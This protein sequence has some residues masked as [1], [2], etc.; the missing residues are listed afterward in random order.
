MDTLDEKERYTHLKEL[1]DWA[2]EKLHNIGFNI[3]SNRDN[4]SPGLITISL[5]N[6]LSSSDLGSKLQD[7][8]YLLHWRSQYLLD[9]NWI[10]IALI[11]R[12]NKNKIKPLFQFLSGLERPFS[13][14][15]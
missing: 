12:Y 2:R 6:W 3:I 14:A 13:K 7:N 1:S 15:L 11:S 4:A 10:Q 9:R 5:P 8:G